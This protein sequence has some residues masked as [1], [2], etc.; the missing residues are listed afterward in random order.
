MEYETA[1]SGN[2]LTFEF[3][4][5]MR[6]LR[7]LG[8][9]K[10]CLGPSPLPLATFAHRICRADHRSGVRSHTVPGS[11]CHPDCAAPSAWRNRV[12]KSP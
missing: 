12:I 8:G 3:L 11:P 9:A 6:L 5:D 4:S 1:E 7:V 2:A 10:A